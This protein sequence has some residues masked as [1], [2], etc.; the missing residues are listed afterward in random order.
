MQN[1]PY[2]FGFQT[3]VNFFIYICKF[4]IQI[5]TMIRLVGDVLMHANRRTGI[6][7][8]WFYS[9]MPKR[10]KISCSRRGIFTRKDLDI[11]V[12]C[13]YLSCWCSSIF[14]LLT[15]EDFK[16]ISICNWHLI[17]SLVTPSPTF[18]IGISMTCEKPFPSNTI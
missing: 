12:A 7:D 15:L 14:G 1:T 9:T 4:Q 8:I 5:F 18:R 11:S 17:L 2:Y 10:V 6:L 3:N 16:S 13:E